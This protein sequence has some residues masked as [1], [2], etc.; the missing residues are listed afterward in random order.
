MSRTKAYKHVFTVFLC[1][2]LFFIKSVYAICPLCTI[3]VGA[4][5]GAA[6][7]AGI[8]DIIIGLWVGGFVVSLIL[9]T[10]YWLDKKKI[11]FKF[12]KLVVTLAY[13]LIMVLPLYFLYMTNRPLDVFFGINKLLFGIILGSVS[14]VVFAQLYQFMKKRNGGK[15]LFPF[16]KVIMPISPLIVLSI[17]FY[18][19]TK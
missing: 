1:V 14:F 10:I 8:D 9:W 11:H 6:E 2:G 16:Q 13:Y 12:R 18:F 15:S 5:I 4:G 3:A 7:Y 17:V 19:I